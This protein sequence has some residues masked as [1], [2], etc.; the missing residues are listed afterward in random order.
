MAGLQAIAITD[1]NS[2]A[3]IVRAHVAAKDS[4]IQLII[5]ARLDFHDAPSVVCLPTDRAAYGRLSSLL[6]I[7]RR[8]APKG[9]CPLYWSD[10][11]GHVKGAAPRPETCLVGTWS[12]GY[13]FPG[14]GEGR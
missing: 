5:G 3:G 13:P 7:G 8:R 14:L 9:E 11:L 6:T 12:F 2:L 10:F 1:R 4:G